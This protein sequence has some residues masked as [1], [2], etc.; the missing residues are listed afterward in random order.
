MTN[1]SNFRRS[2]TSGMHVSY[3][4]N[5]HADFMKNRVH[6]KPNNVEQLLE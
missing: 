1:F 6:L 2:K 4:I 5:K 3:E